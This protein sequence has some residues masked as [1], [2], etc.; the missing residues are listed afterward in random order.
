MGLVA[1][2]GSAANAPV[3]LAVMGV[4]L[5]GWQ[6]LPHLVVVCGVAYA[7]TGHRSIYSAQRAARRKMGRR[8]NAIVHLSELRLDKRRA[9]D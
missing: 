6:V 8:L 1:V 2:F 7:C 4:E 9:S 3:A 5:F